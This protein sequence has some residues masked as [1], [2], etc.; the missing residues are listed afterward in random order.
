MRLERKQVVGGSWRPEDQGAQWNGTCTHRELGNLRGFLQMSS[1]IVSEQ[2]Q[3]KISV[4]L[5]YSTFLLFLFYISVLC[6]FSET[7]YCS[8]LHHLHIS[9]QNNKV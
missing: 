9:F 6:W 2:S 3:F 1:V 4:S 8:K 7:I 5:L